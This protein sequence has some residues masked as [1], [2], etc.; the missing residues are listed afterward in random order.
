MPV[1]P[2]AQVIPCGVDDGFYWYARTAPGVP[3]ARF[4]WSPPTPYECDDVVLDASTSDD[5]GEPPLT[6]E[7][8]VTGD[9]T[10]IGAN[11]TKI[12]TMHCDGV[13][14]AT[15]FL[16]VTNNEGIS[17]NV[18]HVIPQKERLGCILDIYTGNTRFCGQWT[19]NVGKGLNENADAFAPGD[20]VW[21]YADVTYNGAPVNHLLVTFEVWDNT[22]SC[23]TYRVAETNKDGIANTSFRIPVP[24]D[25]QLFGKWLVMASAKVQDVKQMD[26]LKF[27]V[28]WILEITDAWTTF[29]GKAETTFYRPCDDIDFHIVVKNIA[30][31]SKNVTIVIVVY[32]EC[33]VPLGQVI[34]RKTIAGGA[35]CSPNNEPIDLIETIHVPQWAYIGGGK[36]YYNLL[37]ALP[38]ECGVAYSPE[39]S[40]D[41]AIA[42]G[43]RP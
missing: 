23:V 17:S 24:C 37:T 40:T 41:I 15:V 18:T 8:T 19:P 20:W 27:D 43:P 31:I 28:G 33:H 26:F 36:V 30:W 5:G 21:L 39:Y 1:D 12:T 14:N 3:Q 22:N 7:W 16:K 42:L 2:Q 25:V 10:L 35:Y 34:V 9:G 32:D 38:S 13:G 6:Y 11:D 4:T 29:E